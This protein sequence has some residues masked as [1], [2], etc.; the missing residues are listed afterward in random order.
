MGHVDVW[1][2]VFQARGAIA[3]RSYDRRGK[4]KKLEGQEHHE[5]VTGNGGG[6]AGG[7]GGGLGRA[8]KWDRGVCRSWLELALK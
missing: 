5:E 2:N 7:R 6:N 4:M 1:G 3:Q 8:Q